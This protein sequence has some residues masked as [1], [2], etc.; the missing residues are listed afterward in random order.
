VVFLF[1]HQVLPLFYLLE[2]FLRDVRILREILSL[3][4]SPY[5]LSFAAARRPLPNVDDIRIL[6]FFLTFQ[7]IL[8]YSLPPFTLLSF[9][10]I[11]PRIYPRVPSPLLQSTHSSLYPSS[12]L[13]YPPEPV[14]T[15]PDPCS[16]CRSTHDLVSPATSPL[17]C[18]PSPQILTHIS[19]RSPRFPPSPPPSHSHPT[20][21]LSPP[22]FN[23]ISNRLT[24]PFLCPL[25]L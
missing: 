15:P 4:R 22:P 14:Y 11:L 24:L 7:R 17:R 2:Y 8:P 3:D 21:L 19:A 13:A 12:S 20:L 25:L 18:L 5:N 1:R 10:P 9:L 23:V 6:P 16:P